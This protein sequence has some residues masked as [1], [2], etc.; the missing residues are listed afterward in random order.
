MEKSLPTKLGI[1]KGMRGVLINAPADEVKKIDRGELD[2]SSK[3]SGYLDYIHFFTKSLTALN[4]K[5]P[6]LRDHLKPMGMLWISWPKGG[7]QSTDLTLTKIIKIGYD[8]GLVE[9]KTVSVDDAWS[10]IK[11]THPKKG[12]IYNNKYGKLKI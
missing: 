5:F 1:K 7:R 9:S 3:L 8:H 2:L 6:S 11:F 12:K 4:K 10:A